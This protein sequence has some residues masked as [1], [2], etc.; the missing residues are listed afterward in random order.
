MVDT[1]MKSFIIFSDGAQPEV[2]RGGDG[3]AGVLP[4]R[5]HLG[6][7]VH[8]AHGAQEAARVHKVK[9]HQFNI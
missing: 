8:L 9:I 6:A 2:L 4:G 3:P 7:A 5:G 1:Q